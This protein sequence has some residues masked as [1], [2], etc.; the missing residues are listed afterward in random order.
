MNLFKDKK[1]VIGNIAVAI[2]L[3]IFYTLWIRYEVQHE[4]ELGYRASTN[5]DTIAIPI[6]GFTISLWL[7]IIIINVGIVVVNKF[8]RL[9][10]RSS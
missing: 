2:L 3:P 4:Y 8:R 6:F 1:W 9:T 5:G 10:R 7:L